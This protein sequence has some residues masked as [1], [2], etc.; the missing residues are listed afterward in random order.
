M[1]IE[2]P[3]IDQII[4]LILSGKW[5]ALVGLLISLAAWALSAK[6]V[7][8]PITLN[9]KARVLLV[10]IVSALA[11]AVSAASGLTTLGEALAGFAIA[12]AIPIVVLVQELLAES[13]GV[14]KAAGRIVGATLLVLCVMLAACSSVCPIIRV[15]DEV[16]PFIMVELPNGQT[17]RVPCDRVRMMAAE[18]RAARV[19]AEDGGAQ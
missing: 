4:N 3:T 11:S 6:A 15:A 16:C 19:G 5:F 12:Q 17:E 18:Q 8:F 7:W 2:Q 14:K 13:K 9:D 1:N 10:P